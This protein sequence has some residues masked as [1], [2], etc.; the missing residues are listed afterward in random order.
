MAKLPKPTA[1]LWDKANVDKNWLKHQVHFKEAEEIFLNLP[2]KTFRDKKHSQKEDRFTAL[3]ITNK[4]RKLYVVFTI[5]KQKIR[6]ISARSQSRKERRLY[7][8]KD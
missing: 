2:L 1:F 8:K 5:R 6:V 4:G 3:G 7:E